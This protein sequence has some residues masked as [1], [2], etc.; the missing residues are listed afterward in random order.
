T[1]IGRDVT[2]CHPP[3]SLAQVQALVEAVKAGT[4]DSETYWIQRGPAFVLI[5]YYAVRSPEGEY[6][7]VLEC[8]EEISG[9]RALEGQ[10]TL[11]S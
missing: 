1:I 9:L 3:K 5:R 2:D 6:L 4:K 7:G 10:K 8:T 11:M